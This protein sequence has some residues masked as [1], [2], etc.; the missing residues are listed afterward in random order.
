MDKFPKHKIQ[1][2][3]NRQKTHL[4]SSKTHKPTARIPLSSSNFLGDTPKRTQKE[5]SQKALYRISK[6]CNRESFSYEMVYGSSK[7]GKIFTNARKEIPKDELDDIKYK[8]MRLLNF[9][10]RKYAKMVRKSILKKD[11]ITVKIY[12]EKIKKL[13]DLKFEIE[14]V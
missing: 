11:T 2:S 4:P 8:D 9:L 7:K 1:R 14:N 13:I 10:R 6:K 12:K 5:Y 3:F